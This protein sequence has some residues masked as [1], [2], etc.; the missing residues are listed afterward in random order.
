M[1]Q[2]QRLSRY[3]TAG[4]L[5]DDRSMIVEFEHTRMECLTSSNGTFTA[6]M[7]LHWD[8]STKSQEP[9]VFVN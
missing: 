4:E 8:A 5:K 1:L 9:G 2:E 6:V 3:E 7:T